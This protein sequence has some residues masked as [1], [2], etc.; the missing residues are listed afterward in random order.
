MELN[1]LMLIVIKRGKL[2][3]RPQDQ[4]DDRGTFR[5]KGHPDSH[6]LLA[7]CHRECNHAIDAKHGHLL[8]WL[9]SLGGVSLKSI[10]RTFFPPPFSSVF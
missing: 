6:L 10:S 9:S 4:T 5:T 8:K 1:D 2:R 7:R 3:S